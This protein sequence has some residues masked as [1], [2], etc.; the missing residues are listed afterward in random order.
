MPSQRIVYLPE[1]SLTLVRRVSARLP[2]NHF[3]FRTDASTTKHEVKEYLEKVYNVKVARITTSISLGKVRRAP[4]KAKMFRKLRD[5]KRVMVRIMDEGEINGGQTSTL[6]KTDS[7]E[8][9]QVTAKKET[10]R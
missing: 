9:E 4:G 3:L 10:L 2:Y 1:L 7:K 6:G 5:Y 8:E